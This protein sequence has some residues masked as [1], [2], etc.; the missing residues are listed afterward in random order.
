M[1]IKS[2]VRHQY[3][4]MECGYFFRG[5]VFNEDYGKQTAKILLVD[6][7]TAR[8]HVGVWGLG[9]QVVSMDQIVKDWFIL[10]WS[11]K[12]LF[13][14]EVFSDFVT[15]A[16]AL[17][18]DDERIV[19]NLWKYIDD[20]SILIGH[21]I[22]GFDVP[23]I[24][25]RFIYHQ[26]KPPSPFQLIDTHLAIKPLGF[27]SNKLKYVT[28]FLGLKKKL[29][30]D[31]QLWID[32]ENG[33]ERALSYMEKYCR[34]DS[35]ALEEMFVELRPYLKTG[36]NIALHNH[37]GVKCC[38]TCG[39]PELVERGYYYTSVSRFVSYQCSNCGSYSRERTSDL[40]ITDRKKLLSPTAR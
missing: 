28:E 36:I 20:A 24:L 8:M 18:R 23:K 2:G 38:S 17:K 33:D 11:A 32:C 14:N 40:S 9:K 35:V 12:W 21:N 15:P 16:E 30:T 19:L 37:S 31:Y 7:E 5:P 34:Q 29:E 27:S 25:T 39:S 4:C 3:L 22:K 10:G 1:R 6:I 13:S 26:I